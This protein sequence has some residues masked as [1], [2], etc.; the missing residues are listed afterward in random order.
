M[1]ANNPPDLRNAITGDN[2]VYLDQLHTRWLA[3]PRSVSPETA[4]LFESLDDRL[5]QTSAS[6]PHGHRPEPSSHEEALRTAFRVS[7]HLAASLDPLGL[8][9][10]RSCP[11]LSPEGADPALLA[12]LKRVYC[13]SIGA[14]FM[15]LL[16]ATQRQ[17]W[18]D[19][20]EHPS[21]AP[22]PLSP[23]H[24]LTLLTRSEGFESFCQQRFTGMRRFGLEG[25]ESLNVALQTLINKAIQDDGRS[26]SLGM[27][28]RGRLNVM[29][30][31][32]RKPY[33]A[34]FSE[35][36]GKAFHPDGIPVSGDV[37]YHLGTATTL[38]RGTHQLRMALLPNPSH[39]EA[40]DP[41]VMG[42]VRADQDRERD[43]ERSHHLGVLVHGDAAFAGQGVVYE[44][45]QLSRLEGYRTGGTIHL[46]VN[47]QVGFTTGQDAAHSGIWNSDVAKTVQAPILHVNGDDPEAVARCAALAHDWRHTFGTDI[48][49]DIIAYRRHGHNE[50]DDP[51]FTQPAMV[52]RIKNHPTLRRLYARTLEE[53]GVIDSDTAQRVWDDVQQTLERA[54]KDAE[55]YQPDPTEWLDYS[56]QDPTR[57]QDTPQRIQPM[58]GVPLP[59]LKT[60]GEGLTAT[61]RGFHV[62]P[63]LARQ[64]KT[65]DTALNAHGPIDWATAESLAFGTL[66][67][68]GHPVRLSGQDSGRGTFSQR[69]AV[70]TDQKTGETYTPLAHI[71]RRQA[72]VHIW[73]SPLSEYAVMGF[74]YGYSLGNPEALVLWEAQFGDF[75]NGGQIIIDQFLA[76][77]ETKW[78]RTSGLTLLLPH[79]YEGAGPEH[80]SARP[81]RFLQ[82]CAENNLR[83]CMPSTPASF[84][85]A[86]RRQIARRCRK[87]LIVFTPKSLLRHKSAVSTL[88][89]MGPHTRFQPVLSDP[90]TPNN[91]R[92]LV[93]CSGKVYYDLAAARDAQKLDGIAL[94]RMEQL[95][96]YPHHPLAEE[97]A[98]HPNAT[99]IIWCQEEPR[100][101]GA[102]RFIDRRIEYTLRDINHPVS[103]L[104]YVGRD[105][106]ASPATGLASTHKAQQ[107]ALVTAALTGEEEPERTPPS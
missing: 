104:R 84:F 12:Q 70:L 13:G 37:K 16:D 28:H 19:R 2:S 35:F 92:R 1:T 40:I 97:L 105:A 78:L 34:I 79:G 73:N 17:W 53:R 42:R 102:W 30:N 60:V 46:I 23:E 77:G 25:S 69:H 103:R 39:L 31:I 94:I 49:V 95:Y 86:L 48:V 101:S 11:S 76:A 75:A 72:P 54:F 98:R 55:T 43:T 5:P 87:P 66:A 52:E 47:N 81:E 99:D 21:K 27:P 88:E 18:I 44:S 10:A 8:Q 22:L 62:H 91:A 3:D 96:P 58:T 9:Q 85:H 61:P 6:L 90:R 50:T 29:A 14:E 64:L 4:A 26:I 65:R 33:A 45:L 38:Q 15:H 67:L 82:L 20:F 68:D 89:D 7:G 36:A 106:A 93:I 107:D 83:V 24:I 57:L 71:S 56:P 100:N 51:G 41:V 63:R 80:S 32:L 74:D 59:R